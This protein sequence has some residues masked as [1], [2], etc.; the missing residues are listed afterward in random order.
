[1]H[2]GKY[3]LDGN[4]KKNTKGRNN[5]NEQKNYLENIIAHLSSILHLLSRTLQCV[6]KFSNNFMH[7]LSCWQTLSA[8]LQ[9]GSA[10][11][12][13]GSFSEK[14]RNLKKDFFLLYFFLFAIVVS[15]YHK[16]YYKYRSYK[17]FNIWFCHRFEDVIILL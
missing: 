7:F 17:M 1:M 4:K 6:L 13:Y 11:T 2:A 5:L 14:K 10:S 15:F 9:V 16:N 8:W 3:S 12:G